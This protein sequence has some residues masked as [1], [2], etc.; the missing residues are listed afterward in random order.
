MPSITER[1]DWYGTAKSDAINGNDGNN[2]LY[3]NAG[4]DVLT[5]GEGDGVSVL[6]GGEGN[7]RL[8]AGSQSDTFRVTTESDSYYDS[9]GGHSD[10]IVGFD[11]A[12]DLLD[13]TAV[14]YDG[15]GH[16][17]GGRL[18]LI[19]NE[20]LDRTYLRGY[21]YDY[22]PGGDPKLFQVALQG[23]YRTTLTD[24][25]FWHLEERDLF[26]DTLTGTDAGQET[27]SGEGGRDTLDGA[28]GD[29]RIDGGA[30]GDW[31]TGGSGADT[32]FFSAVGDSYRTDTTDVRHRDLITDF[33]AADG[34]LI[35]LS[36]LGFTGLGNGHDGTLKLTVNAAG[37]Q[38]AL[39]SL[40]AD[41]E[42]R[43]FEILFNGN[44]RSEL[45]QGSVIFAS[46]DT[47]SVVEHEV[48]IVGVDSTVPDIA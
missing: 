9:T 36:T 22:T 24:A 27:L 38:T 25:N 4:N 35:D 16:G 28:G 11:P 19:Y 8:V 18:E 7:D 3:G 1:T 43:S 29:D 45:S 2:I 20:A 32:F 44:L 12:H 13:L 30:D 39:K 6:I 34:D 42:G 10:L 14:G 48:G 40:D 17:Y 31:L 5:A 23:D 46:N 33:N 41:A 21:D 37:T 26:D 15:L 47:G